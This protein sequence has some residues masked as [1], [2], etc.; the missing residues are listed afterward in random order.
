MRTLHASLSVLSIMQADNDTEPRQKS[1]L[2]LAMTDLPDGQI[3][4]S[5]LTST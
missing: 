4:P 5:F 1:T 3:F 2:R